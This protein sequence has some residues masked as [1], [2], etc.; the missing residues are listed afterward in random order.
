YESRPTAVPLGDGERKCRRHSACALVELR[1]GQV[2][3]DRASERGGVP[4]SSS[5][6]SSL[7]DSGSFDMRFFRPCATM[8]KVSAMCSSVVLCPGSLMIAANFRH[9]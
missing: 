4:Y 8:I 9:S 7:F 1:D 6:A 3:R 2:R 5:V